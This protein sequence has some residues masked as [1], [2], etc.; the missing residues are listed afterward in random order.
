MRMGPNF[1]WGSW[2]V[3]AAVAATLVAS[4]SAAQGPSLSLAVRPTELVLAGAATGTFTVTNPSANAIQ[5]NASIGDY[6]IQENGKVLVDPQLPPER[7]AK[8]WITLSQK[9]FTLAAHGSFDLTVRSH[10]PAKADP[11]DHHALVLFTT[12]TSGSGRVLVRTRIAV[13][14]L[15]RVV[16]PIKRK[17]AI[18]SLAP[19]PKKHK[20]RLV[21]LNNG[22]INERLLRRSVTVALRRHGRTL[23][24]LVAP[25]RD[26]LPHGRT[27]FVLRY[28]STIRRP[29]AANVTVRPATQAV[30]GALAP[31]SKPI[32][33][34]FQIRA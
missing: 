5:I 32:K 8:G 13:A 21:I 1:H 7:S 3:A 34:T 20:L 17:L 9:S 12:A 4:A 33:K 11:G 29:F 14:L 2:L 30:A 16:G 19:V 31:P 23:Q 18:A 15:A 26:V 6:V 22:N 24:T 10:P 27:V 28:R 25:A